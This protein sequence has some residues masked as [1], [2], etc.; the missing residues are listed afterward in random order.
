MIALSF[1]RTRYASGFRKALFEALVRLTSA[2]ESSKVRTGTR[3][4]ASRIRSAVLVVSAW[5][6]KLA[7]VRETLLKELRL[8]VPREERIRHDVD[9]VRPRAR[10]L[11]AVLQGLPGE[12]DSGASP[13]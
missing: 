12:T 7:F 9:I 13:V 11:E 2:R 5:S 10:T 6:E 3:A 4:R 8:F 1:A